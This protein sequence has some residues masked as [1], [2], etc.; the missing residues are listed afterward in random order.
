[1][2]LQSLTDAN[3]QQEYKVVLSLVNA[4]GIREI[5]LRKSRPTAPSELG[6]VSSE[7]QGG[8]L[9]RVAKSRCCDLPG[10]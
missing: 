9:L 10:W 7:K 6:Y 2:L 8:A 3:G 1:M 5:F 4:A